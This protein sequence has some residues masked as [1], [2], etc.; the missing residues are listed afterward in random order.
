MQGPYGCHSG[1]RTQIQELFSL[2]G[3]WGDPTYVP[4][5]PTSGK[6]QAWWELR[7]EKRNRVWEE[8]LEVIL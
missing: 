3:M 8:G 6:E 2:G 4:Q 5:G 1:F 7:Q